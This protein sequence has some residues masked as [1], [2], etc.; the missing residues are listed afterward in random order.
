MIFKKSKEFSSSYDYMIV[1][2]GNPGRQYESTR[3]NTGF[4]CLDMLAEKYGIS[5]KKLK[6]RSLLGDGRIA[7]KKCLFLQHAPPWEEF[8]VIIAQKP[9]QS[10]GTGENT[11]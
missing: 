1:G 7:D 11:S 9:G 8:L 5:V 10:K 4:I 2:L 3:H 6:F